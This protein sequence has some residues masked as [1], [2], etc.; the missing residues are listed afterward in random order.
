MYINNSNQVMAITLSR[1]S[2]SEGI[3]KLSAYIL[4]SKRSKVKRWLNQPKYKSVNRKARKKKSSKKVPHAI[5]PRL[6]INEDRELKNM[7]IHNI[8]AT[9]SQSWMPE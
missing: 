5:C 4:G 2:P 1:K 8:P 9:K 7:Q 3:K 6:A